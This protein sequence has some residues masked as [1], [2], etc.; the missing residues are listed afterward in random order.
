MV[1]LSTTRCSIMARPEYVRQARELCTRYGV[2][3]IIESQYGAD[4]M[5]VTE[6]VEKA[7]E[8]LKPVLAADQIV[9]HPDIFR[10]ANFIVTAISHLSMA[11]LLGGVLVI[12]VLFLFLLCC[13]IYVFM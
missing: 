7:L 9:L 6:A 5:T 2:M 4:T 10:P 8:G 12:A 13:S 3:L 11:L 1:P